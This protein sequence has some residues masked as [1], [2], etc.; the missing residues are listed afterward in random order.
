MLMFILIFKSLFEELFAEIVPRTTPKL[1]VALWQH[2]KF[3]NRR[4]L[5]GFL[6]SCSDGLG[7]KTKNFDF[8]GKEF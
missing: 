6:S 8:V 5:C 1:W 3:H 4:S 2:G 7:L